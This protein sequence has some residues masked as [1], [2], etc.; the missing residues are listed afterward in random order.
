MFCFIVVLNVSRS[1]IH[2][3]T[4]Q[5]LCNIVGWFD[6]SSTYYVINK[7]NINCINKFESAKR[8]NKT[9]PIY[10][11]ST[12]QFYKF[13]I[14]KGIIKYLKSITKFQETYKKK[15]E[16]SNNEGQAS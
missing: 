12:V 6:A 15:Y 14:T 2:V 13:G 7:N 11:S 8:D 9:L 10:K 4:T 5:Q 3:L 1:N 16:V